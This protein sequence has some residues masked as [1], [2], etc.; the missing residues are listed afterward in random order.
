MEKAD[1]TTEAAIAK[2]KAKAA[3]ESAKPPLPPLFTAAGI[4]Q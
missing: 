2:A 4:H 1:T 3:E